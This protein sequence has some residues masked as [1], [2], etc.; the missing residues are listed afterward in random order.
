MTITGQV[1]IYTS[2]R[3]WTCGLC[4]AFV[5]NNLLHMCPLPTRAEVAALTA[6]RDEARRW[7]IRYR[8]ECEREIEEIE[9]QVERNDRAHEINKRLQDSNM[10]LVAQVSDAEHNLLLAQ[11]YEALLRRVE[12]Y[13]QHRVDCVVFRHP[14]HA[15]D[16]GFSD[17]EREVSNA[18]PPV[19]V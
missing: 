8:Q 10:R 14:M 19:A 17:L 15:C 1:R 18:L 4:G 11:Q 13:A 2:D 7:A 16:C 3:G 6:Q 9:F 5:P 12:P